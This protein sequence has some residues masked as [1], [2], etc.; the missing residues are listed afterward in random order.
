MRYTVTEYDQ[1]AARHGLRRLRIDQALGPIYAPEDLEAV[2]TGETWQSKES[3]P[4]QVGTESAERRPWA[5]HEEHREPYAQAVHRHAWE[6]GPVLL[7]TLYGVCDYCA[8]PFPLDYVAEGPADSARFDGSP[9]PAPL[10]GRR[11]ELVIDHGRRS[12]RPQLF[13]APSCGRAHAAA[14]DKAEAAWRTRLAL[15]EALAAAEATA[16]ALANLGG[17]VFGRCIVFPEG[18]KVPENWPVNR[19]TSTTEDDAM[20]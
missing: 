1:A 5:T 3:Y 13:C 11:S 6:S 18:L 4:V 16:G 8:E 9:D 15:A 10:S 7:V 14:P 17:V 20:A 2:E 12:G 19:T